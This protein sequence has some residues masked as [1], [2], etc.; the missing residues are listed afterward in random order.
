MI[1]RVYAMYNKSRVVLGVLL[2]FYAA[3]IIIYAVF[4]EFYRNPNHLI[5]RCWPLL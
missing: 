5:G 1:L 2:V 3:T 4:E